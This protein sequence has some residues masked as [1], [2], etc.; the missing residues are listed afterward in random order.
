MAIQNINKINNYL[1][2]EKLK[3][4]WFLSNLDKQFP[5]YSIG[6]IL[7]SVIHNYKYSLFGLVVRMHTHSQWGQFVQ[8]KV[9]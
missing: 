7:I 6:K 9:Q 4:A 5:R 2:C 1:T 8:K 3:E